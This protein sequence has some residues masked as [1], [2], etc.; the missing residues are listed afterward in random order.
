MDFPA[1]IFWAAF[2]GPQ[3][4]LTVGTER[5]RRYRPGTAGLIAFEDNEHPAFEDLEPF[6]GVGEPFYAPAWPGATPAGWEIRAE[7]PLVTMA[8]SGG[9][10][11][12]AASAQPVALDAG[13]LP[14]V[15]DLVAR[16]KPGPFGP[17]NLDL[18]RYLGRFED[19]RLVAM[20]GERLHAGRWR[21]VSAVCTEPGCQGRG[22]GG[23]MVNAIVREQLTRGETP[24]LH[25]MASNTGAI[26]LYRKLGF[27][28]VRTALMRVIART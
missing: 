21:E 27:E 13:H 22:L 17:G 19:G 14:A 15:L 10:A 26:S 23:A 7:A 11:P 2:G 28:V 18:G 1:N 4:P 25:V 12:A 20:A 24:F 5:A 3:R 6:C 16:T 8:W 9:P